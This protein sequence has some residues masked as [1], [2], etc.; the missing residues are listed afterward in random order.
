[1][2]IEIEGVVVFKLD[3]FET[4]GLLLIIIGILMYLGGFLIPFSDIIDLVVFRIIISVLW[5]SGIFLFL[6]KKREWNIFSFI[7]IIFIFVGVIANIWAWTC[8][9]IMVLGW[10]ITLIVEIQTEYDTKTVIILSIITI[11][12]TLLAIVPIINLI[13]WYDLG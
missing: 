11:I 4:T 1:V 5:S 12:A 3:R 8:I 13:Q 2:I 7:P 6:M 9:Y 10:V